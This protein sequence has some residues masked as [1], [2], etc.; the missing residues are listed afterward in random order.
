MSVLA[1][2]RA[3]KTSRVVER[4]R[5]VWRGVR[6]GADSAGEVEEEVEGGKMEMWSGL[7]WVVSVAEE[8]GGRGDGRISRLCRCRLWREWLLWTLL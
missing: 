5:E 6:R 1:R 8:G 4:R 2:A 3:A 7:F